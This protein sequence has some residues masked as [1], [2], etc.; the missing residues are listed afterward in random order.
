M[1]D[2]ACDVKES[3]AATLSV[4][5]RGGFV[6]IC[7]FHE[8]LFFGFQ[9]ISINQSVVH[10]YMIVVCIDSRQDSIPKRKQKGKIFAV[11]SVHDSA[12][13]ILLDFDSHCLTPM[14]SKH[15]CEP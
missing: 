2:L 10:N 11:S 3:R 12:S 1:P 14:A 15:T 4:W 9:F 6:G 5:T 7:K 13:P 8:R